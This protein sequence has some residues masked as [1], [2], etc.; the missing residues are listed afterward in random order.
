[1]AG[2]K[3]HLFF[4]DACMRGP[5]NLA[6]PR[7]KIPLLHQPAQRNKK[8]LEMVVEDLALLKEQVRGAVSWIDEKPGDGFG[9]E[10]SGVGSFGEFGSRIDFLVGRLWFSRNEKV[11]IIHLGTWW[12]V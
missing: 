8:P 3:F 12:W 5:K 1:M 10:V 2:E 7:K 9:R 4:C 6:T 11:D